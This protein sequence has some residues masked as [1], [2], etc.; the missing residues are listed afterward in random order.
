MSEA[1]GDSVLIGGILVGAAALNR[2]SID[3]LEAMF[4]F[5]DPDP[6]RGGKTEFEGDILVGVYTT[7]IEG[8]ERPL[9]ASNF[10]LRSAE[11]CP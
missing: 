4:F 6:K 10:V 8:K 2:R 11:R 5:D 3:A 1:N 7:D 9:L